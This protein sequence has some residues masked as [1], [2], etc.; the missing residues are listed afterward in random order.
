MEQVVKNKKLTYTISV[1]VDSNN[2]NNNNHNCV[3][4]ISNVCE[5]KQVVKRKIGNFYHLV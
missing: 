4:Y 1:N 2:D 3:I 5:R